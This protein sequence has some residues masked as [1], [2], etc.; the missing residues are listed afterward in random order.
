MNDLFISSGIL[1][2]LLLIALL[3]LKVMNIERTILVVVKY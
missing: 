2:V 3:G 1:I